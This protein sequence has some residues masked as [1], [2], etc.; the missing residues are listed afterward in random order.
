MLLNGP[1]FSKCFL[2]WEIPI[3]VAHVDLPHL[4]SVTGVSQDL[5]E[6]R[7]QFVTSAALGRNAPSARPQTVLVGP[8]LSSRR[9]AFS[10][11]SSHWP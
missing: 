8:G 6:G 11:Y 7:R 5:S 10:L 3:G 2:R 1:L 4:S 9:R